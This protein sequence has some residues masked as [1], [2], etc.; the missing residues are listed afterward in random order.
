MPPKPVAPAISAVRQGSGSGSAAMDCVPVVTSSRV[1]SGS[2]RTD[3][4]SSA[5]R[6]ASTRSITIVPQT[7]S[8]VRAD[9]STAAPKDRGCNSESGIRNSELDVRA[10]IPAMQ[11]A[12]QPPAITLTRHT[13][14]ASGECSHPPTVPRRNMGLIVAQETARRVR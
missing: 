14:P 5:A 7:R 12:S 9:C 2:M 13:I 1:V 3:G 4:S 11:P 10:C 6:A 8:I